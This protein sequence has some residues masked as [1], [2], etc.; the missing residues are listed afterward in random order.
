MLSD[1]PLVA[2]VS[3]MVVLVVAVAAG[4]FVDPQFLMLA[5]IFS[6]WALGQPIA[7]IAWAA[8]KPRRE[9]K[10]RVLKLQQEAVKVCWEYLHY[11]N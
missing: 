4:L 3:V 2:R 8:N 11:K 1:C 5:I 6:L 7:D 10:A 9:F